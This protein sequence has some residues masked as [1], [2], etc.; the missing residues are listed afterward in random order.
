MRKNIPASKLLENYK[1]KKG[2]GGEDDKNDGKDNKVKTDCTDK[3]KVEEKNVEMTKKA[4]ST[5][6]DTKKKVVPVIE[7]KEVLA[8]QACCKQC[9][10]F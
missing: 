2:G 6:T 4:E 7:G 10:I 5:E 8:D 9:L 1:K 3:N